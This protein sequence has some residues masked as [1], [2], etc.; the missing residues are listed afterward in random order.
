MGQ[1][2]FDDSVGV[3]NCLRPALAEVLQ[4]ADQERTD[5]M[6]A[7][8][9]RNEAQSQPAMATMDVLMPRDGAAEGRRVPVV[10]FGMGFG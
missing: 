4:D 1:I 7:Q 10:E 8:I 9:G 5:R 6:P 3:T 2:V